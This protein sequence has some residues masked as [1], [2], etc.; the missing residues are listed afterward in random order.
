MRME[1]IM[2]F[3]YGAVVPWVQSI[4]GG[5]VATAGPDCLEL[6]PQQQ[7]EGEG[8]RTLCELAVSAG[9]TSS[10]VL[11]YFPSE[12]SP[13]L[14]IDPLAA[15]DMTTGWCLRAVSRLQRRADDSARRGQRLRAL[16]AGGAGPRVPTVA[17]PPCQDPGQT[18]VRSSLDC[19]EQARPVWTLTRR[20]EAP[21][22]APAVQRPPAVCFAGS[23]TVQKDRLAQPCGVTGDPRPDASCLVPT[24]WASSS[25]RLRSRCA[26]AVPA[27]RAQQPVCGPL[28]SQL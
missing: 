20:A 18:L 12:Q 27:S 16:A 19:D 3:D 2:R 28:C 10:F 4:E 15:C 26:L 14:S 21:A 1:L 17:R 6:R 22:S 9:Q 11:T 5:I 8:Y 23:A 25:V 24:R 13:P 7:L